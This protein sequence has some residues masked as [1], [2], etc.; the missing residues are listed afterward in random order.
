[1]ENRYL[2]H[3]SL[4]ALDAES[5]PRCVINE[6]IDRLLVCGERAST[7]ELCVVQTFSCAVYGLVVIGNPGSKILENLLL[8]LIQ[9][10]I[11]LRSHVEKHPSPQ[12]DAVAEHPDDLATGLVIV[13]RRA[14]AP[15]IVDRGTELPLAFRS[16]ERD[17][18]LRS[19]VVAVALHTGVQ[20]YV[21]IQGM[22]ILPELFHMPLVGAA[23]PVAVEPQ[24]IHGTVVGHELAQLIIVEFQE[25]LPLCG[26]F[27]AACR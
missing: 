14:V 17:S 13:V 20:N 21:R 2:F 18:L 26:I 23:L 25:L 1:M 12:S 22:E 15:G 5:L 8:S 24:K 6:E 16:V 10:T 19:L 11:L 9:R 4:H 7:Q 3:R 27:L